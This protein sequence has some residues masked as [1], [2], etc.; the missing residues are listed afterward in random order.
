MIAVKLVLLNGYGAFFKCTKIPASIHNFQFKWVPIWR[1]SISSKAHDTL[2]GRSRV[3]AVWLLPPLSVTL[4]WGE[5]I[6]WLEN[7]LQRG[8]GYDDDL[9]GFHITLPIH[10]FPLASFIFVG[11]LARAY[12]RRTQKDRRGTFTL[13]W[14]YINKRCCI[15]TSVEGS[16]SCAVL[17]LNISRNPVYIKSNGAFCICM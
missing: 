14:Y 3:V 17:L 9:Y 7:V 12:Y 13:F 1:P 10:G 8:D 16:L 4:W 2:Q 15:D 5:T 6:G 11:T